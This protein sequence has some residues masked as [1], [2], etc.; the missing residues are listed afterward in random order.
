MASFRAERLDAAEVLLARP[1]RDDAVGVFATDSPVFGF[2]GS[3]SNRDRDLASR[4]DMI[5]FSC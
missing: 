3:F 1:F 5:L 4:V 2:E